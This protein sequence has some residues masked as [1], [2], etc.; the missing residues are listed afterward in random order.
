MN[1]V[2][3][4]GKIVN[5]DSVKIENAVLKTCS[6]LG[7]DVTDDM[8][9]IASKVENHLL[10]DGIKQIEIEK[11]QDLV[12]KELM[13]INEDIAKEYILYRNKRNRIRRSSVYHQIDEM[14]QAKKNDLTNENGNMNTETPSGM[15]SK[16]GFES[17]KEFAIESLLNHQDRIAHERKDMHI[18]DLDFYLTKSLT[19]IQTDLSKPFKNGFE[20]VNGGVRPPKRISTAVGLTAISIQTSQNEMHG[21]QSIHAFDFHMAPYILLTFKEY[22]KEGLEILDINSTIPDD[23]KIDEY[24]NKELSN[25][26]GL[27]RVYQYAINKT[28]KETKQSMEGL[29]HDLN[30]M[31]SR[32]GNQ[33]PFSSIN[34]GTDTSAEGRLVIKSFL[35]AVKNGVGNE[36][37]TAI[38]PISIFKIKSEINRRPEDKNYD[39]FMFAQEVTAER[40]FPNFI[41][42]DAPFNQNEKWDINDPNRWFYE[43][44]TMGCRTRV[45][46]NRF[47]D[48]S[49]VG[50]GNASF[51]SV[52]IVRVALKSLTI[53]IDLKDRMDFFYKELD[54]VLETAATQL[55]NRWNWQKTAL[56]R[57]FP[58]VMKYI[59]EHNEGI[60]GNDKVEDVIKHFSLS[61]GFIGLAETLVALTS[62]KDASGNYVKGKHHGED[63]T[64]QELGIEII[65]HMYNKCKEFADRYD[66]NFGLLATPAEG[67]SHKFTDSDRIL[68]GNVEG[69][70][71]REYY[72]N[73]THI[74]VYYKTSVFHKAKVEAK[75]H[76][77]TPSGHI[78]YIEMDGNPLDNLQAVKKSIE[79]MLDINI[80][81]VSINHFDNRCLDCG[82]H[83]Y[84]RQPEACP[85]CGSKN[86]DITERITGYLVGTLDKWNRGKFAE[87]RDRVSHSFG[88]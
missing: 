48:N 22:Y 34:F 19:C 84:N 17:A 40:F 44:S 87:Q 37:K 35:Q 52:N 20:T 53:G 80:G 31:N 77:L 64:V 83:F 30:I 7:Y 67:L 66:K 2:K 88:K 55:M 38:F 82:S 25:L 72:T 74:P 29:I 61:I 73:S 51:T 86:I 12:E 62:T 23:I 11:I 47:S 45:Y 5:F 36:R 15:I 6:T 33:V 76:A 42:L 78:F 46:E 26:V 65:T 75:Y 79:Y 68:F 39:L 16:V 58:Y 14:I 49:S 13:H 8:S 56:A 57:Q 60:Q 9:K 24:V 32:S 1:I 18:H 21:G 27:D 28:I 59:A 54:K 41:N 43:P 63:D 70:T 50:R 81:Y 10:K 71:D 85:K 3:R 4:D 69:V